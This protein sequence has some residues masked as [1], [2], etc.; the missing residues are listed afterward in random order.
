[1]KKMILLI[2][3]VLFSAFLPGAELPKA[4]FEM[5]EDGYAALQSVQDVPRANVMAFDRFNIPYLYDNETTWISTLRDGKWV[6]LD[7]SSALQ[8]AKL[9]RTPECIPDVYAS[10][11][12]DNDGALYLLIPKPYRANGSFNNAILIYSP[13]GGKKFQAYPVPMPATQ[14]VMEVQSGGNKIVD[15]PAVLVSRF[16]KQLPGDA[17]YRWARLNE[18]NIFLPRKTAGGLEWGDPILISQEGFGLTPHSGGN[19][20]AVTGEGKLFAAYVRK[21]D[22]LRKGGNPTRILTLDRRTR[23][24]LAD[25]FVMNAAPEWAD[26]HSNPGLVMDHKGILH[27]MTGAHYG[28]SFYHRASAEPHS[29]GTWRE[30]QTV[31]KDQSYVTLVA[32]SRNTLHLTPRNANRLE[33]QFRP[34]N[35]QWSEPVVI[36]WQS[37]D[38]KGYAVYYHHLFIDCNDNLY[39]AFSYND[40]N[41]VNRPKLIAVSP[42]RGKT[43]Q[44]CSTAFLQSQIGKSAE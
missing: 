29:A 4:P 22:D 34:E 16:T 9:A 17:Q 2:H 13:D 35:G 28:R 37:P 25:D 8:A 14:V 42:D 12:I 23:K 30:Q 41:T 15:P 11:T 1:M 40:K 26:I 24:I 39:L 6:K 19:S 10:L 33:Y 43:W 3:A 36:A 21:P 32:D 20:V 18:M 44:L 38:Y 27:L 5:T 7:F 31:G